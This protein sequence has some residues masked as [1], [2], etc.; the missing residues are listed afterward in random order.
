MACSQAWPGCRPGRSGRSM[1]VSTGPRDAVVTGTIWPP[2]RCTPR[3]RHARP[4]ARSR[5]RRY[6]PEPFAMQLPA[7]SPG[8]QWRSTCMCAAPS[9]PPTPPAACTSTRCP[10]PGSASTGSPPRIA[11][12]AGSSGWTRGDRSAR[13]G[14]TRTCSPAIRSIKA[15]SI[16]CAGST[17]ACR[18][19]PS[20]VH[21][22]CGRVDRRAA[23]RRRRPAVHRP[24]AARGDGSGPSQ[25]SLVLDLHAAIDGAPPRSPP[26]VVAVTA[27]SRRPAAWWRRWQAQ[28]CR[29]LH[30]NDLNLSHLR[31]M[32]APGRWRRA[33]GGGEL[34]DLGWS[35]AIS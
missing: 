7:T 27:G 31:F 3:R 30:G 22:R 6:R 32:V 24:S 8:R 34:V 2:A 15:T 11:G 29:D 18:A 28:P 12:D 5:D 21:R 17:G 13:A 10:R 14:R 4:P 35:L 25:G 19:P 16:G 1:R 23:T 26:M 33:A 20:P 9:A